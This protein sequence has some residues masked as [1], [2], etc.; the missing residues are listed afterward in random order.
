MTKTKSYLTLL[1]LNFVFLFLFLNFYSGTIYGKNNLGGGEPG[2]AEFSVF[3]WGLVYYPVGILLSIS[4][5][6]NIVNKFSMVKIKFI[7]KLLIS[8]IILS[9]CW[10]WFLFR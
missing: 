10:T 8:S 9:F 4:F 1:A 3:V 7:H 6:N 5:F 2:L